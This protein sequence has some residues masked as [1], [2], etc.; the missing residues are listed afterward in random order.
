CDLVG[1]DAAAADAVLDDQLLT[2]T[3]TELLR[4]QAGNGVRAAAR[5][6]WDDEADRPLR[7]AR[8]G[9]LRMRCAH[10]KAS[11]EQ[12]QD[13]AS[14]EVGLPCRMYRQNPSNP[15]AK[16]V[17]RNLLGFTQAFDQRAA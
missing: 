15:R 12:H 9:G 3:F 4:D 7:P 14:H 2:Q 1:A 5:G 10:P 11:R 8:D 17:L 6:E 13:Q 16:A